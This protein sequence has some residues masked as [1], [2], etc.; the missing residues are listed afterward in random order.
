MHQ[1]KPNDYQPKIPF[2]ETKEFDIYS[3]IKYW[4]GLNA[5][6]FHVQMLNI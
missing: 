1:Q 6:H 2:T 4:H 5:S 3:P